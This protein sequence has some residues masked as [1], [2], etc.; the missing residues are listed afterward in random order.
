MRMLHLESGLDSG[1]QEYRTLDEV[2]WLNAAG[3]QS[4]I[5]CHPDSEIFQQSLAARVPVLPLVMQSTF[6]PGATWKLYQMVRELS[7]DLVHTHSPKDAWIAAPLRLLGVVI[8]RSRHVTT[9]VK[10]S[11]FRTFC[12][13]FGCDHLIPT[14]EAIRKMFVED[15]H[16]PPEHMT[17]V[18]EG[19]NL[20]QFYPGVDGSSFRLLWGAKP[21]EILFGCV[22]MLRPEKG[23]KIFIQAAKHVYEQIPNARFILIGGHKKV[24]STTP[25][26]YRALIKKIF[27]YDAWQPESGVCLSARTPILM[28]GHAADVA[29]ATAAVDIAVVPSLVGVEGQS[30]T[31]PEALCLGKPLIVTQ[32]GGLCEVVENEKTGLLIPPGNVESLAEAMIRLAKDHELCRRLATAAAE[33]GKKR[34]SLDIRMVEMLGVYEKVLKKSKAF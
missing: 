21:G 30:R 2:R 1:G 4:W 17:V 6:F 27:G 22:G 9:P 28:H 18:G 12:Y 15:N 8:V 10:R 14:A 20:S 19:V 11:F 5:V 25:A 34:F 13:R 7:C 23:Q 3:H 24:G 26:K 33:E 16:I 31:A 32:A 29:H